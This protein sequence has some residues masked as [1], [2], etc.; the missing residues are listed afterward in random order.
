L[1]KTK[2]KME[3]EALF[4]ELKTAL[5]A[6]D[7][8]IDAIAAAM[9]MP[10]RENPAPVDIVEAIYAANPGLREIDIVGS[11]GACGHPVAD[12]DTACIS[13]GETLED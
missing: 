6:D 2:A 8:F 10:A 13:C 1:T 11:C 9:P 3:K 5:I 7:E 12:G 4:Q